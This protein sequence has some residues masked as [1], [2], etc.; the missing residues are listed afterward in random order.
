VKLFR[1]KD[2][3]G[4]GGGV[5]PPPESYEV[6]R[7]PTRDEVVER[8]G[9]AAPSQ[10]AT[11]IAALA[12]AVRFGVRPMADADIP[13]GASKIGGAPDLPPGAGP[14]DAGL[15]FFAQIDMAGVAAV[16]F[17][18]VALGLGLPDAGLL[19]FFASA[20][21]DGLSWDAERAAVLV[22]PPGTPLVRVADVV[23]PVPSGRL[24]PIGVWTWPEV[25]LSEREFDAVDAA[26]IWHEEQIAAAAGGWATEGRHQLGGHARIIH[27]AIE[28]LVFQL[29]SDDALDHMWADAGTL[30]WHGPLATPRF[31]FQSA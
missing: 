22:T 15:R 17:E 12:P 28:D 2:S 20:D 27:R 4:S 6:R 5:V 29:D 3:D 31:D 25:E 7:G 1:R 26:D 24:A 9:R 30:Y 19:S 16:S 21:D 23:D 11:I 18:S 13:L 14:P 8:L 10:G